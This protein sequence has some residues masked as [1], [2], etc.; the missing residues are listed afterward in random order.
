MDFYR[1]IREIEKL[2]DFE[3]EDYLKALANGAFG[4]KEEAVAFLKRPL[5]KILISL[6]KTMLYT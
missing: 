1:Y 5:S 6:L 4:R 2:R 3:S